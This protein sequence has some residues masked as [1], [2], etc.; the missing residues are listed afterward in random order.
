M[1]VVPQKRHIQTEMRCHVGQCLLAGGH[2][3]V[4]VDG[5]QGARHPVD[6]LVEGSQH[7]ITVTN[8][9]VKRGTG[10]SEPPLQ[11][12]GAAEPGLTMVLLWRVPA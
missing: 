4:R 8:E 3:V 11:V 5:H 9:P 1:I 10:R 2:V 12:L 7:V 6:K